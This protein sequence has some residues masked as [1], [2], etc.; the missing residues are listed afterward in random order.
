MDK[1]HQDIARIYKPLNYCMYCGSVDN[2]TDEHII[3]YGLHGPGVLPK[4]SCKDC[5]RETGRFEQ[6]VLR[7]PF[8]GLRAY[9]KL[10]SRRP[11]DAPTS[12]PLGLIRDENREIVELPLAEHPILLHFLQ[13]PPPSILTG[14]HVHGITCKGVFTYNLGK[15]L[16]EVLNQLGAK[17]CQDQQTWKP[18]SFARMIAKVGWAIVLVQR[19]LENPT[20]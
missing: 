13:F 6:H 8:W 7:G 3:P 18:V 20:V 10:K 19:E 12:L 1:P 15:P 16:K 5:A 11:K 2:L 14:N 4:S 9:L 17:S